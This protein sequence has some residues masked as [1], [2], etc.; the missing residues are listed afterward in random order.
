MNADK[1]YIYVRRSHNSYDID[2]VCKLGKTQNIP[3]RDT[4]YATGEL[5]RGYFEDVYE[6][7]REKVGILEKLLQSEFRELNVKYDAGVEF[8]DKKI[9]ELIE[10]YLNTLRL[11]YRRLPKEEI[12]LLVRCNRVKETF[13]KINKNELIQRLTTPKKT[14]H[15][16]KTPPKL[17]S[18]KTNNKIVS[19]TP[20]QDQIE[21]IEKSVEHF[22]HHAK[23]MLTLI[24]GVGKTLISLWI[25]QKLNF[26]T[27]VIGVPNRLLLKQW[28]QMIN[29]LFQETPYLL[30]SLSLIHI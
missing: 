13:K 18:K 29:E 19:Y 27:I 4:Q 5:K 7:P 15:K 21:T 28:E 25:S 12:S 16:K 11:I 30:V 10:P 1:A 3:E 2:G 26:Q 9:I 17:V 14:T 20:R 23:G 8:Y 22:T 6:V 24:C